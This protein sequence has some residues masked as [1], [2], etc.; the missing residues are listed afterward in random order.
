MDINW[1]AKAETFLDQYLAD[2]AGVELKRNTGE[3][4]AENSGRK[5]DFDALALAE[6]GFKQL[7]GPGRRFARLQEL[8]D[9]TPG[10]LITHIRKLDEAG[11][12][13]SEKA[14]AGRGSTTYVGLTARGRIAFD[15]YIATLRTM[16]DP[17]T[18][19]KAQ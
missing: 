2:L 12:T 18:K 6:L 11:Y 14:R 17:V 9:M 5:E 8:L 15:E 4:Q 19:P 10:N 13:T 1:Q 7:H 16:L 3:W